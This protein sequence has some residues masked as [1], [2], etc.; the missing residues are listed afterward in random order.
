[1]SVV[2]QSY[3]HLSMHSSHILSLYHTTWGYDCWKESSCLEGGTFGQN[4]VVSVESQGH[5]HLVWLHVLSYEVTY[6]VSQCFP[7]R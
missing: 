3:S 6:Q 4:Y 1:M 7:P 2:R 5:L